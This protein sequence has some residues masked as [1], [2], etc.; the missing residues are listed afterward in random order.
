MPAPRGPQKAQASGYYPEAR[1]K[2]GADLL[3]RLRSTIGPC[4]L[5]SVFGMGTG[6]ARSVWTPPQP[7]RPCRAGEAEYQKHRDRIEVIGSAKSKPR[8]LARL[9]VAKADDKCDQ[10][11]AH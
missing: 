7:R 6:V 9:V 2:G 10:A 1:I 5:T 3:S 8:Q 11:I 4:G